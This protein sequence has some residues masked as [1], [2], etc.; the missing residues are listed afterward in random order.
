MF[1][2]K[3]LAVAFG[4]LLLAWACLSRRAEGRWKS[5]RQAMLPSMLLIAAGGSLLLWLGDRSGLL[6][7]AS[8]L[9]SATLTQ[10]LA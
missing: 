5:G 3:G 10:D 1:Q 7:T 6:K 9:P 4:F 8:I 2:A